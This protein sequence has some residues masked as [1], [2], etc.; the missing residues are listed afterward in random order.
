M[1]SIFKYETEGQMNKSENGSRIWETAILKEEVSS[2]EELSS[3]EVLFLDN[4]TAVFF[5][6]K[7]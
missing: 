6:P 5:S 3:M 4:I 7:A 1:L 2:Y